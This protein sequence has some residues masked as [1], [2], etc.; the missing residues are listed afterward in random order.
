MMNKSLP[1]G[2]R[3]SSSKPE[4]GFRRVRG[5]WTRL[6]T[7]VPELMHWRQQAQKKSRRFRRL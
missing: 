3:E 5:I 6:L 4:Y 1:G 2:G 7:V